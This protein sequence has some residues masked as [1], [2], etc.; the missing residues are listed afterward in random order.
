MELAIAGEC[1][2]YRGEEF[3]P[4][5]PD[6]GSSVVPLEAAA[7]LFLWVWFTKQIAP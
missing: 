1:V 5:R 3:P 2:Y 4:S 7:R 6:D